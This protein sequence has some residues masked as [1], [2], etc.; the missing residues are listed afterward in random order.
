M[1][2]EAVISAH[3]SVKSA[4]MFGQGRFEA[5]ILVEPVGGDKLQEKN[6]LKGV[7]GANEKANH[8]SS[9]QGK[10][11]EDFVMFTDSAKPTLRTGKGTVSRRRH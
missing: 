1:A 11:M 10:I 8:K 5:G 7:W 4:L 3:P 6:L 2:M 9:G